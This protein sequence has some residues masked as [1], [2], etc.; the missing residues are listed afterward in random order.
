M[1][2]FICIMFKS[3]FVCLSYSCSLLNWPRQSPSPQ[4]RYKLACRRS[5]G[6]LTRQLRAANRNRVPQSHYLHSVCGQLGRKLRVSVEH[7]RK[8]N[9]QTFL[10]IFSTFPSYLS[11][12][13]TK[14]TMVGILL[15]SL[16]ITSNT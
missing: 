15:W 16:M 1:D 10:T 5:D 4:K 8:V 9:Y 6:C 2:C 3:L 7:W 12:L 13:M 11:V 14:L